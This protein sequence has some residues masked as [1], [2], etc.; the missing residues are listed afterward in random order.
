M[1]KL[2]LELKSYIALCNELP[3]KD[4]NEEVYAV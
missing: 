2:N 1:A 3:L 4:F